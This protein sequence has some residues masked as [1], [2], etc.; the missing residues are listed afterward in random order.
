MTTQLGTSP[1]AKNDFI[2]KYLYMTYV[3]E[4]P[5]G[6]VFATI[7]LMSGEDVIQFRRGTLPEDRIR[8][9]TVRALVDSGA[10]TLCIN[11]L[12]QQQLG[13]LKVDEQ[14][15]ELADGSRQVLDVVGPVEMRF[16]NRRASVDALV[17]PGTSEVLLGAIPLE[18]MDVLID[19]KN[20]RLV[21][22][23]ASPY[24]AQA[25]VKSPRP[26]RA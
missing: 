17:L 12:I 20:Q 10:V 25:K 5:M 24:M 4:A 2:P 18:S 22:N 7:D 14:T 11:E 8:R 15:V 19:A 3:E 21:V 6:M 16:E 1:L 9:V 13:L 26:P 23:P